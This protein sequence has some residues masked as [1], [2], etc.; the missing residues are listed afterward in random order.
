MN[1]V[2]ALIFDTGLA[3]VESRKLKDWSV[4][5]FKLRKPGQIFLSNS[6]MKEVKMTPKEIFD[7]LL[8]SF[9]TSL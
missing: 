2:N 5:N 6:F 4:A 3:M 8:T 7:F 1:S 9:T